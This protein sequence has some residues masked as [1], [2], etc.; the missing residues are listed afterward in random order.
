MSLPL[1]IK[2]NIN[3]FEHKKHENLLKI[4]QIFNINFSFECDMEKIYEG[5]FTTNKTN[6]GE[7]I[8]ENYLGWLAVNLAQRMSNPDL[9]DTFIK[10]ITSRII[11]FKLGDIERKYKNHPQPKHYPCSEIINGIYF[12]VV[13]KD[14]FGSDYKYTGRDI[15]EYFCL[16]Q[17]ETPNCPSHMEHKPGPFTLEI[18]ENIKHYQHKSIEHLTRLNQTLGVE[19]NFSVD[20]ESLHQNLPA[21]IFKKNMGEIIFDHYLGGLTNAIIELITKHPEKRI[22]MLAKIDTKKII[23]DTFSEYENNTSRI[24]FKNGSMFIY[25]KETDFGFLPETI[26]NNLNSLL[27]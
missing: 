16:L 14:Y 10:T 13:H 25:V 24:L 23:F 12:I 22:S 26:G 21:S 27:I 19:L 17:G 15:F 8:Y 9:Y 6:I 3:S 1:I 2:K 4:K 7:I 20:F 11:S 18:Q 5:I